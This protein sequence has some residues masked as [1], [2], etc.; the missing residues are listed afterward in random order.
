V[1]RLRGNDGRIDGSD[2]GRDDILDADNSIWSIEAMASR[3]I[4]SS[5]S[6]WST[7]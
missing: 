7:R 3:V 1:L 5:S 6:A 2:I 4:V